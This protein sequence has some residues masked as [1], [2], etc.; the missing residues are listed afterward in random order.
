M[1]A[2][3]KF[4]AMVVAVKKMLSSACDHFRYSNRKR[5]AALSHTQK[6]VIPPTRISARCEEGMVAK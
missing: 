3:P 4:T 6:K 2:R 5:G 1:N